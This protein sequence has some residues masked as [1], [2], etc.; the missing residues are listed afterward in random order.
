M[1]FINVLFS[2]IVAV[3]V[4]AVYI[5]LVS[6]LLLGRKPYKNHRD[7]LK[8]FFLTET[9]VIIMAF[10]GSVFYV[11]GMLRWKY[12][13][14]AVLLSYI[15][16]TAEIFFLYMLY[17]ESFKTCLVISAFYEMLEYFATNIGII[18]APNIEFHMEILSERILYYIFAYGFTTVIEGALVFILYRSRMCKILKHWTRQKEFH[19]SGIIFL[20]L[21]PVSREVMYIII[22]MGE[23][24]GDN[25]IT[26]SI[27]FVLVSYII[28]N[29]AEREEMHK[30][31]LETQRIS[32]QQQNSYIKTL[33]GLQQDMRRFRHDYKNMMSGMY[34]HAKEGN[35]EA[36]QDFIS[37]M[38]MDFD[39][40]VG[41]QIRRITQL[42]N[43]HMIEVKGLLLN[44]MEEMQKEKINCEI[45][46]LRPF[47]KTRLRSTDLCRCLGILIDN[48][49]DEVRGKED[50]QV[51]IM[52]SSQ[53]DYTTFRVKNLLYSV[54][55]FHKIWQYGY[56]TRGT[57]RG[58]GL[59]SYKKILEGYE[60]IIPLAAV[61]DGYFIQELKIQE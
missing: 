13:V 16:M 35:M 33:E 21:Y 22:Q 26:V 59:A 12:H 8:M 48:A 41:G 25:N 61:Q 53:E 5:L 52:I 32:L 11:Q 30:R 55:D 47:Y 37:D 3:H 42:G 51:H 23:R 27:L 29:Y 39:S 46:V 44:K 45:E 6:T 9:F 15:M 36:I 49:I 56:S 18:F 50:P 17:H 24:V 7:I 34:I 20:F 31:Q 58:M 38:A 60:D 4:S 43:I 1:E 14:G 54:V 40:Q 2:N 57:D 28:F 10:V 19:M